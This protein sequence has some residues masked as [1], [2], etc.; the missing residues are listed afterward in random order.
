MFVATFDPPPAPARPRTVSPF[1]PIWGI[2]IPPLAPGVP[3]TTS[4]IL[5]FDER[6][7]QET[8]DE[9]NRAFAAIFAEP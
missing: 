1:F 8:E 9:V 2:P 5:P 6:S 4:I 7:Q 3:Y